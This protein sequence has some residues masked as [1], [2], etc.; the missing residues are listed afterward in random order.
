MSYHF[1]QAIKTK[2]LPPTDFRGS[3]ISAQS[4][5]RTMFFKWDH[6]LDPDE[7]HHA[8]A[9]SLAGVMGW[10]NKHDLAGGTLKSGECVFVLVEKGRP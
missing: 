10:L 2:Y 4:A 5:A 8:A 7:N 9:H 1:F 3:R 6:G